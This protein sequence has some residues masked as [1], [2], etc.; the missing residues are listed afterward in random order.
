MGGK[1]KEVEEH[2]VWSSVSVRCLPSREFA[3]IPGGLVS[4]VD[5][6]SNMR[7]ETRPANIHA[8]SVMIRR[9]GTPLRHMCPQRPSCEPCSHL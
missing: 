5:H 6:L 1:S 4:H 9:G 8:T 2:H 3:C 7:G